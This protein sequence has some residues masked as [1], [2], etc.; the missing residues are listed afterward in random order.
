[1]PTLSQ[2]L[3][4][5]SRHYKEK[6]PLSVLQAAAGTLVNLIIRHRCTLAF[7]AHLNTPREPSAWGPRER[8]LIFGPDNLDEL[9]PELLSTMDPE[10]HR[11]ELE[12]LRRGN[13]LFVVAF[14][15]YCLHRGYIS[16]VETS[17]HTKDRKIIFFGDL[18]DAPLLRMSVNT[19]YLRR[20][21][22]FR[23]VSKGLY[24]R[25]LNEQL[26]Y[27]QG[28]GHKRAVLYIMAENT[29]S[30]KATIAAGFQLTRV[31]NDFVLFRCLL[32]QK[33][34]ELG[35]RKWRILWR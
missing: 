6:G 3:A 14:D 30:I 26:R 33:V 8:L 19:H 13:R 15:S 25:V 17:G 21:D 10:T 4:R 16:I 1:M 18:G 29:L 20:K 11:E 28:L 24:A 35:V 31:L 5:L 22:I 32:V 7:E 12:S 23:H 27:L 9:T 2:L 34:C